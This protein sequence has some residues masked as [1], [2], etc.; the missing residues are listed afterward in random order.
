MVARKKETTKK[1]SSTSPEN[2]S[3]SIEQT[4]YE[5]WQQRGCPHGSDW[6]DWFEA[7]KNMK[8]SKR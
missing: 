7:E 1:S 6:T 3:M 8:T 2:C 4:A 5:L